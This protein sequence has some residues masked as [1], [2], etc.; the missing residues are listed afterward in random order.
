MPTITLW[1]VTFLASEARM[2][3]MLSSSARINFVLALLLGFSRNVAAY[4]LGWEAG[5]GVHLVPDIAVS[6]RKLV[7]ESGQ[8]GEIDLV[9]TVRVRR[10]SARPN[11]RRVVGQNVVDV[12]GFRFVGADDASVKRHVVGHS[13]VVGD[14]FLQSE[15]LR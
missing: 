12:M 11:V 8:D 9:R 2:C 15:V 6:R 14:A 1:L 3:R 4:L 7:A 13:C 10:V 5:K